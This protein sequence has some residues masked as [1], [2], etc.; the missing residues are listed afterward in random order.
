M[1]SPLARLLPASSSNCHSLL[2][3]LSLTTLAQRFNQPVT[4]KTATAY[5]ASL[6]PLTKEQLIQAFSGALDEARFLPVPA[7]LHDFALI[8][9]HAP[10]P[11][12]VDRQTWCKALSLVLST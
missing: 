12:R 8:G 1:R 7:L 2:I 11:G 6:S 3:L 9:D 5:V 10:G 4:D